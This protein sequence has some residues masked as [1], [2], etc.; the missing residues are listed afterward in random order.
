MMF[1]MKATPKPPRPPGPD[2]PSKQNVFTT[3]EVAYLLCVSR[4]T[5][6]KFMKERRLIGFRIH[7]DRRFPRDE[8]IRFMRS[9]GIPLDV[10]THGSPCC[11]KALKPKDMR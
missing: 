1:L 8:V 10:C 6:A 9:E 2:L 4:R 7:K 3:G 11:S 5:V